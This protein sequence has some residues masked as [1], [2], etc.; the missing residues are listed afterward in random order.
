MV[1]RNLHEQ[2]CPG[3]SYDNFRVKNPEYA[4][5]RDT[6]STKG[7]LD[8]VPLKLREQNIAISLDEM[9]DAPYLWLPDIIKKEMIMHGF[10]R[11]EAY[12]PAY[13]RR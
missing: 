6:E 5:I 12:K 3:F 8:S 1:K 7:A 4:A 2:N 9:H 10:A 13:R 11:L